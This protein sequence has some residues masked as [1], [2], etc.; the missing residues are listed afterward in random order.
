MRLHRAILA[1]A[2]VGLSPLIGCGGSSAVGSP[3]DAEAAYRGLDLAIDKAITLGFQG[4]VAAK[5]ANIPAQTANGNAAGTM[6]VTGKVDQGQ[7]NNKTMNLFVAV[8]GYSD[9]GKLTYDG[10]QAALGMSLKKIPNG[11]FSGSLTGSFSMSGA[12]VGPA[13]FA[14]SFSGNL[15]PNAMTGDVE[16]KPGT[17]HITGSVTSDQYS[18]S[19]DV[20][21]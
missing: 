9:D 19:V 20:T 16:R 17:T 8:A 6:T 10:S 12:L 4:F 14:L 5:S 11:D 1:C 13:D 2:L 21:R 18:Y 15:E 7:S 3:A